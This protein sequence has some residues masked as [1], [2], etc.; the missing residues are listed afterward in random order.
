MKN[1]N[2]LKKSILLFA[3]GTSGIGFSQTSFGTAQTN[4]FG[5]SGLSA[6]TFPQLVD[7][8][9]DGDQ[10]IFANDFG[11]NTVY[12]YENT[13]SASAPAYSA[14]VPN[15]FGISAA[16]I[17]APTFTDI[18]GDGDQDCFCGIPTGGFLYFKN[19]GTVSAPAFDAPITNP[20]GLSSQGPLAFFAW[21][22]LDSDGVIDVVVGKEI[23]DHI[24]IKN[25]GSST[26]PAFG[27]IQT[28]PFGLSNVGTYPGVAFVDLDEDGDLDLLDGMGDGNF[29]Y[30]LN[31][32]SPTAPA[33]SA[34][35]TNPYGLAATGQYNAPTFGDLD[36]DGD[37]DLIA[38]EFLGSFKYYENTSSVS[39][40]GINE[41][42]N[43]IVLDIYPNPAT[44]QFNLNAKG[45]GNLTIMSL[46]GDIKSTVQVSA[47]ANKIDVSN[48]SQ[49][50]YLLNFQNADIQQTKK[51]ILK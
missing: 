11:S 22:D 48:L 14:P 17:G 21:A 12:Y 2:S 34:A 28:N 43:E 18:D 15:I 7:I 29:K 35:L 13:G 27:S 49:G 32:G 3:I 5:L 19:I 40:S 51:L 45:A 8:D 50:F 20:F 33:F 1:Y 25:T 42:P 36:N 31:S 39:G 38:G 10:D 47:G 30:W 44:N 24:F 9:D 23:G 4:P 26:A 16:A 46:N 41:I 37:L 6:S